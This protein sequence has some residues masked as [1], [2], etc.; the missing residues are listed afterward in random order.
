MVGF[1]DPLLKTSAMKTF[2]KGVYTITGRDG[3]RYVCQNNKTGATTARMGYELLLVPS[4]TLEFVAPE[5]SINTTK[6]Q[7]GKEPPAEEK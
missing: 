4:N 7:T 5:D 6:L 3:R 1:K 2:T